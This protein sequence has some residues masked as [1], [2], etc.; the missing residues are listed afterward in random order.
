MKQVVENVI[1]NDIGRAITAWILVFGCVFSALVYSYF[2][3]KSI[4]QAFDTKR[5]TVET[6]ELSEQ[7]NALEASYL[8]LQNSATLAQ[9]RSMGL[10]ETSN[11]HF[12]H[13]QSVGQALSLRDEL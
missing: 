12:I 13:R 3:S 11:Q 2:V 8:S 6:S 1:T 5:F 10:V 7:L 4:F 9:A